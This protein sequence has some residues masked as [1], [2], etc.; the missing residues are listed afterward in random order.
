LKSILASNET[1]T[2]LR[3]TEN[4]N[5]VT[6]GDVKGV[7]EKKFWKK[8]VARRA[9]IGVLFEDGEVR[10]EVP[11]GLRGKGVKGKRGGGKGKGRGLKELKARSDD[12]GTASD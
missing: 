12:E 9:D 10:K 6:E 2:W 11:I 7:V 8:V 1:I 3:N 5:I 4:G